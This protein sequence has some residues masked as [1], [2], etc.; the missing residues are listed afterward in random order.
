[1]FENLLKM[2]Y[3]ILLLWKSF[4]NPNKKNHAEKGEDAARELWFVTT[5]VNPIS[6]QVFYQKWTL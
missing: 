3:P 1:M 6:Y 2:H 4:L 5:I